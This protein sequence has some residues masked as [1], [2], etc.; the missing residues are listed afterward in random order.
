M[1]ADWISDVALLLCL[2]I[3]T[4]SAV[5]KQGIEIIKEK[6]GDGNLINPSEKKW[7]SKELSV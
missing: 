3:I 2:E 6:S 4:S 1:A 7:I 5:C